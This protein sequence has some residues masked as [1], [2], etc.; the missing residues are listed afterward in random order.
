MEQLAALDRRAE[1]PLAALGQC[2]VEELARAIRRKRWRYRVLQAEKEAAVVEINEAANE[3][4]GRDDEASTS[5][6]AAENE[7]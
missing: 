4:Y 1:E 6:A 3:V 7:E 2:M 5:A